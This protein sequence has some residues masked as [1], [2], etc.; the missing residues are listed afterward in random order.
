MLALLVILTL[1]S[2]HEVLGTTGKGL[3]RHSELHEAKNLIDALSSK[4]NLNLQTY[5]SKY[6]KLKQQSNEMSARSGS[7][8]DEIRLLKKLKG[9]LNDLTQNSLICEKFY[10]S[11][12]F[13]ISRKIMLNS[14][15]LVPK[16]Y[17]V[18]LQ[19]NHRELIDNDLALPNGNDLRVYFYNNKDC[20]PRE[21]DRIVEN[22]ATTKTKVLFKLQEDFTKTLRD[23]SAYYIVYGNK[24]ADRAKQNPE[25]VYL[26]YDDF[27]D[28]NFGKRW[29]KNWGTVTVENGVL[30]LNTDRT[31]TGDYA[32][33]S[34]FV[35]NGEEW[36]DIEVELDFN[37]L[38][39]NVAPGPFLRVHDAKIRSTTA[40]WFEYVTGRKVNFCTMR[41][42]QN[43]QDG[44]WLYARNR[45]SIL[46]AGTWYHAKYR[47]VGDRFFHWL[48]NKLI[49][50]NLQVA[51]KWMIT[52]GTFGLGCHSHTA[53]CRT[54]Y[55]NIKITK[56]IPV[57]P[58]SVFL[59]KECKVDLAK[60]RG[61]GTEMNP[62]TSCKQIHD[63]SLLDGKH[64][65]KNGVYWIK[66][67]ADRSAPT[68]CDI[69]N[70]GWT[71]I[72]KVGGF[73]DGLYK[74]W[75][76][77]DYNLHALK[78]PA[79][80]SQVSCI[81]ARYLATYHASTVMFSSGDNQ[82]TI[83]SKWVQWS[84]PEGRESD[85]LW[86]HSVGYETVKKAKMYHVT[87]N[88]WNGNTKVCYQNK[89][90]I[91]P[92]PQHGGSYPSASYN[93]AGNTR[94]NDYCMAVGVLKSGR[95]ADGWRQNANGYDS[96]RSNSDWPNSRYNHQSPFVTVWV[97]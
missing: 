30:K 54:S 27:S 63:V 12:D 10:T 80:P 31:P 22:V 77:K 71:L 60:F 57:L 13:T 29:Q 24:E 21:L 61:I 97:K 16:D 7:T 17:T 18:T 74:Y 92:H 75:L 68:Y 49:H 79:L 83:G 11:F 41:P 37:E 82:T 91:M 19:V 2:N 52:K 46:S 8:K 40:W 69:N 84:L 53:G 95:T 6:Y 58:T 47:V 94:T 39:S 65:L 88:A 85:S 72:G 38:R 5:Q 43:N 56:Y 42:Y 23:G 34:V 45:A 96:P 90:A 55:D 67:S 89:Y 50:D 36:K 4:L 44:K 64:R 35:K 70:G 62:A 51:S 20:Q 33:I 73:V 81:D 86:T 3:E 28:Q 25:N 14:S 78:S 93:T 66:T 32:D 9:L 1:A 87:V 76:I 59:G 48:N 26:F 15:T